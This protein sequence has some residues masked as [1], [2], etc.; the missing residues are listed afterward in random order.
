MFKFIILLA[1]L[2]CTAHAADSTEYCAGIVYGP[3][4]AFKIDAPE[5]WVLD[6]TSGAAMKLHCVLYPEGETWTDSPV[7]MY[8]RIAS[9][10]H[11]NI[12]EFI[13]YSVAEF[14][15]QSKDFHLKEFKRG[16]VNT[17]EYI[18]MDYSNG[19]YENYERVAYFQMDKAVGYVVFSSVTEEGF[20]E[21]ADALL[22]LTQ[23]FTYMP[24]FINYSPD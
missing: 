6:N 24:A 11:E 3:K 12:R 8:A 21:H 7:I 20:A 23:T 19:P 10:T 9:T 17:H 5:G 4:A 13:K 14:R 18:V 15:S 1:A 2:T 16:E 22:Q